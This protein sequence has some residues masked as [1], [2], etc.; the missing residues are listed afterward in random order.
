MKLSVD[1]FAKRKYWVAD[2]KQQKF[3]DRSTGNVY[4]KIGGIPQELCYVIAKSGW[5]YFWISI[6][7]F[8]W[9][10]FECRKVYPKVKNYID[11]LRDVHGYKSTPFNFREMWDMYKQTLPEVM[12]KNIP[13]N[14]Y[15]EIR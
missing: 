3:F 1:T 10:R 15:G 12:I 6:P 4:R 5:T 14:T 13:L 7:L 11:V 8:F 2:C 9:I